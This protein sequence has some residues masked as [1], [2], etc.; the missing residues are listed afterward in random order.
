MF[1]W[2]ELQKAIVLAKNVL[3]SDIKYM[4]LWQLTILNESDAKAKLI[5]LNAKYLAT[6]FLSIL[7]PSMLN[8]SQAV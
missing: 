1:S 4:Q 6:V 3:S 2:I 7:I 8:N 5:E